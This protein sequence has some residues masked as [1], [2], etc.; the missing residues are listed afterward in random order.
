MDTNDDLCESVRY[1]TVTVGFEH[2]VGTSVVYVDDVATGIIAALEKGKAGERYILGGDNLLLKEL[3][4]L[5]LDLLGQ[6]KTILTLPNPLIRGIAKIGQTFHLPL[7]FNPAVI[8]YAVRYWL[9]NNTKARNELGID[10]RSARETLT[11]TLR[12]L[13]DAEG[14]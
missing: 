8:P 3:A 10:F 2:F 1:A 7:P 12:W 6:K 4:E 14:L 11:P 5:T 9:M 13:Q